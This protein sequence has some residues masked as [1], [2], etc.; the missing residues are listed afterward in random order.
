[1]PANIPAVTDTTWQQDA[2]LRLDWQ[3][4]GFIAPVF[5]PE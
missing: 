5:S 1:M 4:A 2:R 3:G